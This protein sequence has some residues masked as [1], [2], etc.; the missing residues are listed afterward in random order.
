M[1]PPRCEPSASAHAGGPGIFTSGVEPAPP[2]EDTEVRRI[3]QEMDTTFRVCLAGPQPDWNESLERLRKLKEVKEVSPVQVMSITATPNDQYFAS[4]WGL[5]TISAEQAW[6]TTAGAATVTVAVVDTGVDV[7]HPDLASNLVL[8]PGL[9]FVHVNP[10]IP[11]RTGW[12]WEGDYLGTDPNPNDNVGHGTHVAGIAAAVTNNGVGIA[13]VAGWCRILPLRAMTREPRG[14][15]GP[16]S[17]SG[18]SPDIARAFAGRRTAGLRSST[19]ASAAGTRSMSEM[20]LPTRSPR[21]ASSSRPWEMT[22]PRPRP[23]QRPTP[24]YSPSGR[25]M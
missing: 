3:A 4:Q 7:A 24:A 10:S 23:I 22:T 17:A 9:N 1:T 13:G 6:D 25:S 8:A 18:L 19:A 14:C 2:A 15:D 16:D 5:Q 20:P 11:P 12:V 21:A